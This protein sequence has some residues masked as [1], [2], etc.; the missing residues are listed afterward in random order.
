MVFSLATLF[1]CKKIAIS[2]IMDLESHIFLPPHL[3]AAG[4]WKQLVQMSI[5][6]HYYT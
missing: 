5:V 2:Y 6:D 4:A 1:D 3:T